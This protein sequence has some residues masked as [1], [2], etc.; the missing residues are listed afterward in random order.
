MTAHVQGV[1]SGVTVLDDD[2]KDLVV[3]EDERERSVCLGDR[4]VGSEGQLAEDGGHNGGDEGLA[5][6]HGAVSAV[7]HG[8]EEDLERDTLA[9]GQQRLNG[10][11]HKGHVVNVVVVVDEAE[12]SYGLGRVVGDGRGDVGVESIGDGIEH[13]GVHVGVNGPVRVGVVTSGDKDGVT[14]GDGD[15]DN[16]CRRCLDVGLDMGDVSNESMT[17]NE[18]GNLH[19][20]LR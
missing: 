1:L 19:H 8:V 18:L 9:S 14:L 16:V 2:V 10:E 12:V 4:G 5:V 15:G 20:R 13:V 6:E 3:F 7:V 17:M 11:G